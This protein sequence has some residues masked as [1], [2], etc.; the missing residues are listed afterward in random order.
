MLFK[1]KKECK[2]CK[3]LEQDIIRLQD[4]LKTERSVNERIRR[5]EAERV[6]KN[7]DLLLAEIEALKLVNDKLENAKQKSG[8]ESDDSKY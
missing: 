3:K 5:H 4:E 8:E 1:K 2:R 7:Y 6:R